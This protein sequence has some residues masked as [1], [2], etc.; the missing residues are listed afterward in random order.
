VP[1]SKEGSLIDIGLASAAVDIATRRHAGKI[2]E[3]Y[4]PMGK[5]WIQH[6]K[7]LLQTK[8]VVGTGGIFAYGEEPLCI[9]RGACY[10]H[11]SPESLRPTDPEF[12]VDERY[13]LYAVGLLAEVTPV[14]ALKIMKKYL[15]K[16]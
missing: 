10:D 2:E 4:F 16:V 14:K 12:F 6:G 5:V 1:K 8:C 13:I 7:D 3:I 9:L 11:S 15:R